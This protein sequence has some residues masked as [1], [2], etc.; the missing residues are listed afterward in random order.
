MTT[1]H[2]RSAELARWM[3]E[4]GGSAFVEIMN[5]GRV[6]VYRYMV[7]GPGSHQSFDY[8]STTCSG[9]PDVRIENNGLLAWAAYSGDRCDDAST[10]ET[11]KA[12]QAIWHDVEAV[13]LA[14]DLMPGH[15]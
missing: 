3:R 12:F 14:D 4:P 6:A 2:E 9:G 1:M 13:A 8:Y 5:A 15:A 10:S 11:A 7:S